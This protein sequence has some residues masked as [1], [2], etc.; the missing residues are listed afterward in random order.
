MSCDC[1][2]AEADV[3]KLIPNQRQARVAAARRLAFRLPR[4]T[5]PGSVTVFLREPAALRHTHAPDS[6]HAHEH[7]NNWFT[8]VVMERL[9]LAG[10]FTR[11]PPVRSGAVQVPEYTAHRTRQQSDTLIPRWF[12]H[13][14]G[15]TEGCARLNEADPGARR[16]L[17]RRTGHRS[18]RPDL[19]MTRRSAEI[20]S[21]NQP[22]SYEFIRPTPGCTG[23]NGPVISGRE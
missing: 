15:A 2:R 10:M 8:Y 1:Q 12:V 5:F 21:L 13:E 20:V 9:G 14:A 19:G 17:R 16:E 11:L 4:L 23:P 22:H 6:E 18:G 7:I 3:R